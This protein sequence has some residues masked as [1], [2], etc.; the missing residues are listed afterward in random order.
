MA[1]PE[2]IVHY[3]KVLSPSGTRTRHQYHRGSEKLPYT[4]EHGK[5]KGIEVLE[6]VY[7]SRCREASAYV[8]E[9]QRER[10][11]IP[12]WFARSRAQHSHL[13]RKAHECRSNLSPSLFEYHGKR[14]TGREPTPDDDRW[15]RSEDQIAWDSRVYKLGMDEREIHFGEVDWNKSAEWPVIRDYDVDDPAGEPTG[16]WGQ[17]MEE[18]RQS[19]VPVESVDWNQGSTRA[20]GASQALEN[21]KTDSFDDMSAV[22]TEGGLP[23]PKISIYPEAIHSGRTSSPDQASKAEQDLQW[24]RDQEEP[25][26]AVPVLEGFREHSDRPWTREDE[27]LL[28]KLIRETSVTD[29]Q[30]ISD[31]TQRTIE[32]CHAR[33]RYLANLEVEVQEPRTGNWSHDNDETLMRFRIKYWMTDWDRIAYHCG[34][35]TAEARRQWQRLTFYDPDAPSKIAEDQEL[36]ATESSVASAQ[37]FEAEIVIDT[38]VKK[39]R[40]RARDAD[41]E[42]EEGEIACDNEAEEAVPAKKAKLGNRSHGAT[43]TKAKVGKKRGREADS[44]TVAEERTTA[45]RSSLAKCSRCQRVLERPLLVLRQL[46]RRPA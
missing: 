39:G 46:Q 1:E 37:E 10:N 5:Q 29:F 9:T 15:P 4:N 30:E 23:T 32:Q 8:K 11:D 13:K 40:K 2:H 35:T 16:K 7:N 6:A 26:T 25:Q 36:V 22:A 33:Y 12:D 14:M 31:L 44:E 19:R 17:E 3:S 20:E 41:S 21:D 34:T 38:S 28:L 42:I 43:A 45:K 27:N 18:E 24:D